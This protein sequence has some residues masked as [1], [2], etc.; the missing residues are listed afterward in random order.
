MII[1]IYTDAHFSISSSI[2]TG[3]AEGTGLSKRLD[4]LVKSFEWMYKKFDEKGVDLIINCG[5]LTDSDVLRAEENA[6]LAKSLSFSRKVS[7]IHLLG[8]HDIKDASR[9]F[10]SIELLSGYPFIRV[11]RNLEE[12]N[13][14]GL[15]L[16]F[17][18]FTDKE[19]DKVQIN[20]TARD[21][22]EPC[23]LFSHLAYKGYGLWDILA[24]EGLNKDILLENTNLR[25]I[26]NG[27]IH[28]ALD[29]ERYH[30]IGSL[31]GGSFS[32]SYKNGFP[33]II[34]YNTETDSIERIN[35]PY[36]FLFINRSFSSSSEINEYLKKL[37]ENKK[38]LLA[39]VPLNLR[40][41]MIAYLGDHKEDLNLEGFRVRHVFSEDKIKGLPADNE[42]EN[43]YRARTEAEILHDFFLEEASSLP[44]EIEVMDR[45]LEKHFS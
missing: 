8:N 31:A 22:Q 16:I 6:A 18:P 17:A 34:I 20:R 44:Y 30:Q 23:V 32:D 38:C 12:E 10:S 5:D 14:N 41:S 9:N 43:E 27:H 40:D 29:M 36:S 3:K 1:G 15:K 19:K 13:I 35:N 33:G 2:L 11:I 7:E 21:C 39:K 25:R 4:C 26:F 28:Q 37:P 45:F 24:Q 42:T